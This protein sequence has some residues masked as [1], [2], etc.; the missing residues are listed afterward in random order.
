MNQPKTRGLWS[1]HFLFMAL[2]AGI[3]VLA[4]P[5]PI[6][7]SPALAQSDRGAENGDRLPVLLAQNFLQQPGP[8]PGITGG[9]VVAQQGGVFPG[10]AVF[11]LAPGQTVRLA[12]F[13]TDLFG[14]PPDA[15]TRFTGGGLARVTLAD[16]SSAHLAG[17]I[18]AGTLAIRGRSDS[19]DPVRRDGSLALDLYLGN[20]SPAPVQVAIQPGTQ[21]T[22]AGQADQ[23]LPEGADRLFAQAAQKRLAYSNTLQFAVWAARGSTAEEVEQTNLLRL[24]SQEIARVQELLDASSIRKD[25]DCNRGL[26][27]ARYDAAVEQL[28]DK[29]REVKGTA[30]VAGGKAFVEGIRT[31]DGTGWVK[32]RPTRVRGEFY[33]KAAFEKQKNGRFSVKLFHLATGRSLR[34]NRGGF[35]LY[36]A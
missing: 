35:L 8:V 16:G 6:S 27:A 29:A 13:C 33:Y 21:I 22:P 9:P 7:G 11:S 26:Y 15:T 24:S 23:P 5:F 36:P 31:A 10:G 17:A 20:L 14:D 25:F 3:A 19:F 2:V 4:G 30:A 12:A 1:A 34:V 28:G 32:V 18:Q